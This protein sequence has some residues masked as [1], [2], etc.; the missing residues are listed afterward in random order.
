M[1]HIRLKQLHRKSTLCD[2]TLVLYSLGTHV[3]LE[4]TKVPPNIDVD[5]LPADTFNRESGKEI[6]DCKLKVIYI[7]P[8]L[9]QG[10]SEDEGLKTSGHQNPNSNSVKGMAF[11]KGISLSPQV[12]KDNTVVKSGSQYEE[13]LVAITVEESLK[14]LDANLTADSQSSFILLV[15]NFLIDSLAYPCDDN[16][17]TSA[18]T[19]NTLNDLI[20]GEESQSFWLVLS[21]LYGQPIVVYIP[22]HEHKKGG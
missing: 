20:F 12:E 19:A 17:S 18:V 1:W 4:S 7:S 8:S 15:L 21:R 2:Q 22:E 3:S 11:N 6:E 9:A 5:D 16:L 10:N 13:A 14:R